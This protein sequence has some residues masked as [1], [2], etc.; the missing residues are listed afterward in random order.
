[1]NAGAG[2][3]LASGQTLN[4]DSNNT[5]VGDVTA[6]SGSVVSG[7]GTFANNVT[8][9]SGSILRVGDAN[10][11]APTPTTLD[12]LFSN[13]SGTTYD[14]GSFRLDFGANQDLQAQTF[15]YSFTDAAT[16]VTFTADLTA[17]AN[18]DNA[19]ATN[20]QVTSTGGT[21]AAGV[22]GTSTGGGN[23]A[24]DFDNAGSQGGESLGFTVSNI[25]QTGGPAISGLAFDGFSEI[26]LYFSDNPGD[27][28][29][30]TDGTSDIWTFSG[31]LGTAGNSS[32]DNL[33]AFCGYQHSLDRGC[34]GYFA[35]FG[36]IRIA[37][38]W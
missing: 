6:D 29:A 4:N 31:P 17:T 12:S 10:G 34:L 26:T 2:I 25:Q 7:Q 36:S 35:S 9:Q 18:S 23:G 14:R 28:G 16:G 38:G 3:T 13:G 27:A 11:P 33:Y 21:G 22:G 19:G 32:D 20:L 8:A 1:M 30:V 15:T 37:F 5:V 24:I